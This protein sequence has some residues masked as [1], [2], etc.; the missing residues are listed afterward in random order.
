MLFAPVG[1]SAPPREL[2]E[3]KGCLK[4]PRPYRNVRQET[5]QLVIGRMCRVEERDR[6]CQ[7]RITNSKSINHGPSMGGELGQYFVQLTA[8]APGFAW[9]KQTVLQ[10]PRGV[11][12]QKGERGS[13]AQCR[14]EL[15]EVLGFAGAQI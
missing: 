13:V 8:N 6:C 7:T 12:V 11:F 2:P 15:F 1:Q 10:I 3:R 5:S 14:Q 4:K 9:F